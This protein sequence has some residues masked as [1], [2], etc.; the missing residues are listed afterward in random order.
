MALASATEQMAVSNAA[1]QW[2]LDDENRHIWVEDACRAAAN[3]FPETV[4][5]TEDLNQLC[6]DIDK[7][8][9]WIGYSLEA[10]QA[11]TNPPISEI[12]PQAKNNEIHQFVFD[13]L[14]HNKVPKDLS[15]S[16]AKETVVYFEQ[17]ATILFNAV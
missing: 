1:S 17:L 11:I 5:S 14:K 4:S 9:V 10:C 16:Q 15:G 2:I 12:V 6:N 3:R 7:C 8:L 13:W